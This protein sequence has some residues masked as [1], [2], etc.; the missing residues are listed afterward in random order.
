MANRPK[1][2]DF[3]VSQVR[4]YLE[5]GP[6]VLVSSAHAGARNIMTMG[7]QTVMEFTPSLV[8]CVISSAN[9]SF[10]MIR[11]SRECVINLPTTKLTD[12]VV[13]IGNTTGAE[14]DKFERFGLDRREGVARRRAADRRMPRQFRVPAPRRRLGREAQLLHLRGREGACRRR[15]RST[16]KPCTVPFHG[17]GTPL[18]G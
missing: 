8:G 15:R 3:P 1:K 14:I 5:P 16:R 2:T 17:I 9:H 12:V 18:R 4:R 13:G 6:I 10:E 11:L 7:W